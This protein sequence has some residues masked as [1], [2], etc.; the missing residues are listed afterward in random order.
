MGGGGAGQLQTVGVS[1]IKNLNIHGCNCFRLMPPKTMNKDSCCQ[2]CGS[3]VHTIVFCSKRPCPCCGKSHS[4]GLLDCPIHTRVLTRQEA[5]VKREQAAAKRVTAKT[6]AVAA[7]Q[8]ARAAE[9]TRK[10]ALVAVYDSLKPF[11]VEVR[12]WSMFTA[13]NWAT[14][15]VTFCLR[16]GKPESKYGCWCMQF[17]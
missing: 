14:E 3:N 15:S 6:A 10:A 12:N 16:C 1:G 8:K 9:T 13:T 11:G 2:L 7:R 5:K 4:R 17:R